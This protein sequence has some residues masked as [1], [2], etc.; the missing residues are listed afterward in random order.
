ME[1]EPAARY[2]CATCIPAERCATPPDRGARRAPTRRYR[3]RGTCLRPEHSSAAALGLIG[4]RGV[5]INIRPRAPKFAI[6]TAT[7][8]SGYSSASRSQVRAV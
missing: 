4:G 6:C 8:Q 1:T 3:L 7:R 2:R 5:D